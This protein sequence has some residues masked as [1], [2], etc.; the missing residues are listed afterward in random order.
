MVNHA[1]KNDYYYPGPDDARR[2]ITSTDCDNLNRPVE[3]YL[4]SKEL[5]EAVNVAIAIRRPLLIKGEPGSGKTRLARDVAFQLDLL[6]DH[7]FEWF[8]KST[9]RARDGLYTYDTIARLHDSQLDSFGKLDPLIQAQIKNNPDYYVHYG[10]LGSAFLLTD[11][12]SVVL[13]DE[14]DKA[15]IDF[16]NDL[17][18]ELDERLFYIEELDKK[19]VIAQQPPIVIITSNNEKDLPDAFLRRC[20]FFYIEFP[21]PAELVEIVKAHFK[22]NADQQFMAMV[23]ELVALF[24][25]L[26]TRMVNGQTGKKVSTSELIDWGNALLAFQDY[27]DLDHFYEKLLYPG[28]LLKTWEDYQQYSKQMKEVLAE[29]KKK[30]TLV[31]QNTTQGA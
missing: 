31:A 13:I 21:K 8:V 15:D 29:Y 24:L 30:K 28:V 27:A 23:D 9:D 6:K 10:K 17:L 19:A 12:R 16:P 7:Y 25:D 3:P 26:R 14:I 11:R 4:P 18:V 5:A 22:Q 20:L 1:L 2:P